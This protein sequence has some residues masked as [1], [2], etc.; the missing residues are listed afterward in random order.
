[1]QHESYRP[2]HYVPALAPMQQ[3]MPDF[4]AYAHAVPLLPLQFPS[5]QHLDARIATACEHARTVDG[6]AASTIAGYQGAYQRFRAYLI[7]TNTEKDFV[8][9]HLQM[10]VRILEGW[11]AWL[12]ARGATHTT[13]N[14]YWRALHAPL[15][16]I[17]RHDG[18]ADPTRYM[19]SPRPGK[20]IPRFLTRDSLETVFAFV[21][22]YQWAGGRFEAVRNLTLLACMALAGLRFGEV[23]RLQVADVDV[24]ARTLRVERAKG[25]NGGKDRVAYM[26]DPLCAAMHAYLQQRQQLDTAIPQL[27]VSTAGDRAVGRITVRRL[28]ALVRQKTGIRIAPHML[29]HT[30]ATLLR[31][32]GVPDRLAMEQ[33]GHTTLAMLQRYSHVA[34]G[35]LEH[36]MRLVDVD[37]GGPTTKTKNAL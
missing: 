1:M 24:S 22:N 35:E 9:G 3:G 10:Q 20:R 16:R 28:C 26:P 18:V 2:Q 19:V 17:A 14:S 32:S 25:R 4:A 13:V 15:A 37:F 21:R 7:A 36:A 5:L 30:C 33:L 27:F 31:Q 11:I 23:L 8:G 6:L 29:R 12:R 34:N